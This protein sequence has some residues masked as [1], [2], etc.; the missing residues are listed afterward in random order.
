[1]PLQNGIFVITEDDRCPLYNV[2]DR[3][4]VN[5]EILTL[6]TAKPTCLTLT[7]SLL[8]VISEAEDYE[9]LHYG[10]H[11][12]I[13]FQCGGCVGLIHFEFEREKGYETIQMELLKASERKEKIKNVAEYAR[14]LRSIDTFS[15]LK[16]D[17]LLDLAALLEF[18]DF[19]WSFP[20]I[21]KGDPGV[22]L[23]IIVQGR[24]D[25]VDEQGITL[26]TM[27]RGD[28]FGEMSLLS[29]DPV[30]LTIIAVEPCH[31]AMLSQKN[32]QHILTKYP[33]LQ[34]FFYRLLIKRITEINKQRAEELSSGMVGQIADIS[35][36]ELCQMFNTNQKTG[37]LKLEDEKNRAIL[38][39]N[40]GDLVH[41]Q[42]G[43]K[44]GK[45]AFF[46]IFTLN[47][48]RFKFTQGLNTKE[49]QHQP[50]GGFMALMLEGLKRLD[51]THK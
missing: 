19:P 36:I 42:L 29:G 48:G 47:E 35:I 22:Y 28:V 44:K 18:K 14:L 24:V 33:P 20:I 46:S 26:A 50:L 45:E 5:Q 12:K 6:P 3:L 31:I 30:T 1:M 34:V 49:K 2:G 7:K 4:T 51:D 8:R 43:D 11:K 9:E 21:Q 16:N 15:P 10:E 23:H 17:D 40:R 13:S 27:T 41:A 37:V 32:F 39:F 38:I 25:V